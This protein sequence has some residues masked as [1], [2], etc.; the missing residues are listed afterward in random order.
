M[1]PEYEAKVLDISPD[2]VAARIADLSGQQVAGPIVQRRYVYDIAAGDATRWIRLR[3]AGGKV[4][5]ATKHIAHDGID[6]TFEVE[7]GVDDF[8]AANELLRT[9]GFVPKSYQENRRTSFLLDGVQ[10]E[11]DEW[12]LIPPYLEI[13]GP[14]AVDVHRVAAVLGYDESQLTSE[15]TTKIYRRYGIELADHSELRLE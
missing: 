6:G 13:E 8:A 15:N 7:V 2:A 11:I 10:L 5:L 9:L 14:S 12:P 3:D 4:T 1:P